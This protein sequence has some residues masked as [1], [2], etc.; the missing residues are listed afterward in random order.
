MG[1]SVGTDEEGAEIVG[2]RGWIFVRGEGGTDRFVDVVVP[3]EVEGRF[4]LPD[5]ENGDDGDEEEGVGPVL[6]DR[7]RLAWGLVGDRPR[8]QSPPFDEPSFSEEPLESLEPD[9]RRETPRALEESLES[10]MLIGEL[11]TLRRF[12]RNALVFFRRGWALL[13]LDPAPRLPPP[14]PVELASS[15][16][17][18]SVWLLEDWAWSG[19]LRVKG[20]LG[21]A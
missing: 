19:K 9:R 4:T 7:F 17:V 13:L 5:L 8:P 15:R 2:R 14:P 16:S 21:L 18:S 6:E 11:L 10:W 12:L 3:A 1:E 20:W